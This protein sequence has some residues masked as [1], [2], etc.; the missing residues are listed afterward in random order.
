FT[1]PAA[2][3]TED[4][5]EENMIDKIVDARRRS[6]GVQYL[7]HWVGYDRDHDKWL[8]GKMVEDTVAL[9]IWEAENVNKLIYE[10]ASEARH[11][12]RRPSIFLDKMK[13]KFPWY[14]H[15]HML[16][17]GN[18]VYDPSVLA[19]SVT[20]LDTS[21]LTD[22]LSAPC[23]HSPDWDETA[24][25]RN[26]HSFDD[27]N[28]LEAQ[29]SSPP[30]E[31]DP[32]A[33][34]MPPT[35]PAPDLP[36]ATPPKA[37]EPEAPKS[38]KHKNAFDHV[39]EL[40]E[41]QCSLH[42]DAERV[43]AD[44]KRQQAVIYQETC[45]AVEKVKAENLERQRQH[46][47]DPLDRQITLAQLRG[48]QQALLAGPSRQLDSSFYNLRPSH[49]APEFPYSSNSSTSFDFNTS[50]SDLA[51]DSDYYGFASK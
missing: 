48:N 35:L 9:N 28:D 22:K 1:R 13:T 29:R 46:E 40:T 25:D 16:L 11:S 10:P 45:L 20:P 38:L 24:L 5:T 3:V 17:C 47:L 21:M 42:V 27:D 41:I 2:V 44:R 4:G 33:N 39:K 23:H 26:L 37:V 31:P 34:P 43:K 14:K 49:S 32:L 51:F 15:V 7:V 8:S 18:P 30:P 12:T 50:A 6:R 19:N 36:P